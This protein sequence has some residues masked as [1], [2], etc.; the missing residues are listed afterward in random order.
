MNLVEIKFEFDI[1]FEVIFDF[2]G[3]INIDL[4]I[5]NLFFIWMQ[6]NFVEN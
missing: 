6:Y 5:V 1:L 2:I 4:V 3:Y